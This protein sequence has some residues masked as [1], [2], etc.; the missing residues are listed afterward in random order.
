VRF[1]L[2]NHPLLLMITLARVDSAVTRNNRT[3]SERFFIEKHSSLRLPEWR[4]DQKK[5]LWHCLSSLALKPLFETSS[6]NTLSIIFRQ[7]LIKCTK[8][9]YSQNLLRLS[10]NRKISLTV[11]Q[12]HIL[13]I[14]VLNAIML[15]V[16]FYQKTVVVQNKLNSLLKNHF[17]N[18]WT[19]Q[20]IQLKTV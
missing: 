13:L 19:L 6:R 4:V 8:R 16:T 1:H 17:Y 15:S 2:S 9:S 20:L 5:V 12:C 10:Y 14:A 11:A 7:L 3:S 18:V